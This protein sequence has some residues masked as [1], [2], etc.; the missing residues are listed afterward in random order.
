MGLAGDGR[1]AVSPAGLATTYDAINAAIFLTAG[2]SHR[3]RR[4]FVSFLDVQPGHRVLELGCGTGQVTA[5]LA[6]AG[7]SV[8]AVDRLPEMLEAARRRAPAARFVE[9]DVASVPLEGT[10]DVVVL[11]FL[12]HSFDAEGRRALLRRSADA[13]PVGGRIGILDWSSPR[14]AIRSSL[15]RR[16]IGRLEPS[17]TAREVVDGALRADLAAES[18]SVVRSRPVAGHRAEVL[19]AERASGGAT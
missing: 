16:F 13:L 9:A 8:V 5:E 10:F 2:G 19:V 1:C 3:L 14:D 15:W 6:K 18:L 7:A 11:S 12:L 17:P 4:T